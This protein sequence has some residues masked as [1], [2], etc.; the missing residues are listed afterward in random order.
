MGNRRGPRSPARRC[1][2]AGP[3]YK[4]QDGRS[5]RAGL[6]TAHA[7]HAEEVIR[8]P[9]DSQSAHRRSEKSA[10]APTSPRDALA[11]SFLSRAGY[12]LFERAS[13]SE[14]RAIGPVP[15]WCLEIW[16]EAV[17]PG[18]API[19]LG[20]RSPFLETFLFEAE[21]LW[22]GEAGESLRSGDWEESTGAGATIP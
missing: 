1:R 17:R 21:Q 22:R 4:R 10:S 13:G 2:E 19:R 11:E 9:H 6:S 18:A 3:P 12:A 8:L 20:D 7:R 16:G 14:F 15:D 5:R